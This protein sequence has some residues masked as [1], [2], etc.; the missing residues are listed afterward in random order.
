M[1]KNER[2]VESAKMNIKELFVKNRTMII[3]ML[4]AFLLGIGVMG[5]F[6]SNLLSSSDPKESSKIHILCMGVDKFVPMDQRV[7][8]SNS[9]GQADGIFLLALDVKKR[10]L[11]IVSI[12][13]DTMVTIEKY[14]SDLDYMGSEEAQICLQ[15][16]YADGLKK[17][18]ELMVDRVEELFEGVEIDGYVSINMA[19]V[20]EINDAVGGVTV[21]VE[22]ADTA[23]KMGVEPG[24]EVKLT[25]ENIS[26]F[27]QSRDKTES[28][29]AYGRT[30]RFKE[31]VTAFIP[32]GV[33]AIKKDPGLVADMMDILEENMVTNLSVT[34]IAN[35]AAHISGMSTKNI[36]YNTLQGEIILGEDGY[37]ELYPDE[38]QLEELRKIVY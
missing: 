38:K 21:T 7:E 9:I 35:L 30:L 23:Y 2:N 3:G 32:Q 17:S 8:G 19:S 14:Y 25:S 22:N 10:T 27:I 6:N 20:V 12:S 29:S 34:D 4:G 31:Y 33:A 24:S 36:S 18:C 5:V 11:D 26:L 37:E 28:E 15:Y 16:A 13:R 1:G